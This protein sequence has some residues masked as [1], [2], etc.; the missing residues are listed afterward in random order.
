MVDINYL[1]IISRLHPGIT[2]ANDNQQQENL[3]VKMIEIDACGLQCPGPILKLKKALDEINNQEIIK[4]QAS[5]IGFF[6]DVKTWTKHTNNQLLDVRVDNGKVIATIKKTNQDIQQNSEKVNG[7][8]IVVFSNDFDKL[9]ASF[10]I[11]NGAL[12]MHSDVTLFFTFWGLSALRK[13]NY[14]AK[15]KSFMEKMFSIMLPKGSKKTNLSKMKMLGQGSRL[16]RYIMKTKNVD[17][18]ESLIQEYL[19]NGGKIVACTMSMDIMGIKSEELI[20]GVELGGVATYIGDAK[21]AY[22]N[23]FI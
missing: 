1:Q 10:I 4:I 16:M 3:Q 15:N 6:E 21:N 19:S 17:S 8:T 12:A 13:E 23:L 2:K 20:D 22:N 5:D 9:M 18:L 14:Q 7:Q 11:A